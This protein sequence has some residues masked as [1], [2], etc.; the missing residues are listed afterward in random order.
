MHKQTEDRSHRKRFY[1]GVEITSAKRTSRSQNSE[2]LSKALVLTTLLA[3]TFYSL[4][5]YFTSS[6][7]D[8][9]T[10]KCLTDLY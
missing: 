3:V 4:M 8:S 5:L 6:S 1:P 7:V 2:I 9:F 10:I